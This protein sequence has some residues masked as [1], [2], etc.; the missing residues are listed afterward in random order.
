MITRKNILNISIKI[1]VFTTM[2]FLFIQCNLNNNVKYNPNIFVAD[3]TY[4]TLFPWDDVKL[5]LNKSID[6]ERFSGC[7][8]CPKCGTNSE[9]LIWIKFRSPDWTWE[10]LVGRQGPLSICPDCKIQV[11]F[12]TRV[13]N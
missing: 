4:R 7:K 5:C 3:T 1:L 11:Q 2:T 6:S 10:R 12:F 13:M 8:E 9:D